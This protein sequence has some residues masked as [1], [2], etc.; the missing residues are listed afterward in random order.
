MEN[1]EF[2]L[3]AKTFHGLEEVLAKELISL[4]ANDVEIG[5]R[6]VSFTGD[7]E[8]MYRANFCLRTAVRILKPLKEFKANDAD[9]L[10]EAAK[11]IEWTDYMDVNT[12]F[13]IDTVVYSDEFRHSKFVAYKVK[14]GIADYFRE[15]TGDR[16]NVVLTN[17][18]LYINV[19]IA[20]DLVSISL[21]SSGESLHKRGYRVATVDAPINEVLAAG[22]IM[23]TG[24][25]GECDLV[26]PMCGSGTILVEAALIARNIWPGLFRKEFAF[27]KWKDFDPDL[28]E[29]I[30]NDDSQEREFHHHIYGYDIN[31]NVV[32]GAQKNA[33]AAGVSDI[34]TVEQRDMADF[35]QPEEKAIM[36]TNPPYG[37][38]ITTDDLLAFYELIGKKLKHEFVDN[39]AWII[40]YRQECFDSIGMRPSTKYAL[41]NGALECEFRKYQIFSGRLSDR[42]EEGLDIKTDEDRKRN[43]HYKPHTSSRS[44]NDDVREQS[45]FEHNRVPFGKRGEEQR[46][47]REPR[48]QKEEIDERHL[49]FL[50]RF[51]HSLDGDIPQT[52]KMNRDSQPQ[53]EDNEGD[54]RPRR[55]F[56][57][58][59]EDRDGDKRPRRNFKDRYRREDSEDDERPRRSFRDRRED[60]DGDERP[61]RSFRDR[62]QRDDRRGDRRGDR[63]NQR[64]YE[65]KGK[66]YKRDKDKPTDAT[67]EK[68]GF[69]KDGKPFKRNDK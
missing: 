17:P 64:R 26:D 9:E 51:G 33:Q 6:M 40:S 68:W 8:M 2:K 41:F 45:R 61:R 44:H 12:T 1:Q 31:R 10:Y 38:R 27:E 60:R 3:I 48:E 46:E 58:R 42:R 49:R 28:L 18:K 22:M 39:D 20:D 54:E 55:S 69:D 34:V 47:Q 56:R 19:H 29:S 43:L 57:D 5:N 66:R 4:G 14:D 63:K 11:S 16:P 62:P 53:H 59:G 32:S 23:L 13:R 65:D 24:W 30:Y 52:E 67:T 25:D 37:E 36:V 35:K 21:D 15:K 50:R 7:K